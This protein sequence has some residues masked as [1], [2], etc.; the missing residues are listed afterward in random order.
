MIGG[1]IFSTAMD[2]VTLEKEALKLSSY[3]KAHL[4]DSLLS[5]LD[6]DL[7]REIEQAWADESEKRYSAYKAGKIEAVDGSQVIDKI[8]Q[9]LAG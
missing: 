1:I 5:S 2:N 7:D 8:R 9:E 4:V 6:G 3:E